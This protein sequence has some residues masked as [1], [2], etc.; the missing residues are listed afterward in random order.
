MEKADSFLIS[1][2][3]DSE[4]GYGGRGPRFGRPIRFPRSTSCCFHV[5]QEHLEGPVIACGVK[6]M[7]EEHK[8][9]EGLWELYYYYYATQVVHFLDGKDWHQN[10]NPTM[11]KIL[12]DKQMTVANG[13]KP[14]DIGSFPKDSQFIGKFRGQAR[15]HVRSACLTLEV[16][17]HTFRSANAYAA[18]GLNEFPRKARTSN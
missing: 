15:H 1:V 9:S 16:Y 6:K 4:A 8:P 14:A 5:H 10:W 11:R 7:W 17:Y 3:D 18:G 13:A 12:L 2:S